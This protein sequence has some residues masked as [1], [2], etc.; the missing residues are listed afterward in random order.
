MDSESVGASSGDNAFVVVARVV[1]DERLAGV[2]VVLESKKCGMRGS[3]VKGTASEAID[4]FPWPDN[5]RVN[6]R[7]WHWAKQSAI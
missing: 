7:S 3:V 6:V 1:F 2:G 4:S 5:I